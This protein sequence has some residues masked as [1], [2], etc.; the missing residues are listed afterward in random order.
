MKSLSFLEKEPLFTL[1]LC[2][3]Y[4]GGAGSVTMPV[5]ALNSDNVR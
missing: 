4:G 3:S 1:K 2:P 5:L